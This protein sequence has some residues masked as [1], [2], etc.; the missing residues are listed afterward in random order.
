M[1]YYKLDKNNKTVPISAEE[2]F[3]NTFDNKLFRTAKGGIII[4]TIFLGI[5]HSYGSGEITL[6]Q[7]MVFGV[8]DDM[9]D[10]IQQRYST[11]DA[12]KLGHQRLVDEYIDTEP[13]E[14]TINSLEHCEV[15]AQVQGQC[16]C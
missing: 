4:S 1:R 3:N 2:F 15:C 14:T 5:D 7:S 12:A 8:V 13:E 9:E 6:F 11:Y 10:E 16:K